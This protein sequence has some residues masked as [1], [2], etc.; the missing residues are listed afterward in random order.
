M[1]QATLAAILSNGGTTSSEAGGRSSEVDGGTDGVAADSG[2]PDLLLLGS[3]ALFGT[4]LALFALRL[5]AR[6]VR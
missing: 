4:G 6:R 2:R 3:A 5:A 1:A